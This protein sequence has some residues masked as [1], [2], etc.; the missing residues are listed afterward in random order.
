MRRIPTPTCYTFSTGVE[1]GRGIDKLG[2]FFMTIISY[3]KLCVHV[4]VC[5][6]RGVDKLR[7]FLF[8]VHTTILLE[9]MRILLYCIFFFFLHGL[10]FRSSVRG[11]RLRSTAGAVGRQSALGQKKQQQQ[12]QQT[13]VSLSFH[14]LLYVLLCVPLQPAFYDNSRAHLQSGGCCWLFPSLPGRFCSLSKVSAFF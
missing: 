9:N 8:F 6:G 10:L 1:G 12:E 2:L 7:L 11:W 14:V 3:L 4:H 13:C 5:G